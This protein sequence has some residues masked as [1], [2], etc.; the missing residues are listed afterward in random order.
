MQATA[1]IAASGQGLRM[2]TNEKKQYMLLEGVPILARAINAFSNHS[3]FEQIIAVIPPGELSYTRKMM[4]PFCPIHRIIFVEGGKSRQESVF[5]GLQ[6]VAPQAELVCIHDG[7][8][9]LVDSDLID[10]VLDGA[11]R[12]GAAIPA[13]SVTDTIKQVDERSVITG[14][15]PRIALRRAQTPQAFR[16]NLIMDAYRQAS[17]LGIEAT[18][19]SYLLELL[20][21]NVYAVAGDHTNIKITGPEDLLIATAMLK[22]DS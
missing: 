13:V 2:G 17:L 5:I 8:R 19:D 4:K 11:M 22:G 20:G 15:V 12:W 1:V 14:T 6:A 18:D 3:S 7:V 9:P 10:R 16:L 21:Q